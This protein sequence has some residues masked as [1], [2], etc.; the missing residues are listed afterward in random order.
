MCQ[1]GGRGRGDGRGSQLVADEIAGADVR[2]IE[3][4][5]GAE[6]VGAFSDAGADEEDLLDIPV[7]DVAMQGKTMG[8]VERS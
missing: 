1:S 3:E 6:G 2:D 7:F 8:A 4:V 5:A